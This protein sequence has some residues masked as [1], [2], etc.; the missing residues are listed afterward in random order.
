[1]A[2]RKQIIEEDLPS[3]S[4]AS[5]VAPVRQT[6]IIVQ[7]QASVEETRRRPVSRVHAIQRKKTWTQSIA[8]ALVGDGTN[9]VGGYILHEVLLPAAKTT[10]Q[11][12]VTGGIEMILYGESGGRSKRGGRDRERSTINYSRF[13][14]RDRDDDRRERRRPVVSRDKF[15]LNEI[16]FRDHSDAEDV[17]E[18]LCDRLDEYKEVSV[19]DYFELANIDGVTHAHYKW[20]WDALK[21]AFITHTRH[22]WQIVLPDPEPLD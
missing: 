12:M 1:M 22:G 18:E 10:I 16:F 2:K 13:S 15:D 9:S 5:R 3:N 6:S 17:L 21:K 7:D 20:G 11:E 14:S 8:E 19:A 4:K